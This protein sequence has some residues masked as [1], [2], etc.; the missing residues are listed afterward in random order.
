MRERRRSG[1]E[2]RNRKTQGT[3][4]DFPGSSL[5]TGRS[6]AFQA[7]WPCL[8]L[9]KWNL[10]QNGKQA[11]NRQGGGNAPNELISGSNDQST[12]VTHQC[13][14]KTTPGKWYTIIDNG[15][16]VSGRRDSSSRGSLNFRQE[17][18]VQKQQADELDIN[19]R[20]KS[21]L[22]YH[23]LALIF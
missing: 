22:A 13:H 11:L 14:S 4:C 18:N 23:K 6:Q 2:R 7:T 15:R 5:T 12:E 3:L 20:K 16:N 17:N 21:C 8:F 10:F 9:S 19:S 1:Q